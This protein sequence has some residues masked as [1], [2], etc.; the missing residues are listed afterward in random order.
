MSLT[1]P[2][3]GL[4]L[5]VAAAVPLA[6]Q[7]PEYGRFWLG[8]DIGAGQGAVRCAS[9]NPEYR[10]GLAGHV[11]FGGMATRRLHYG[12]E[13]SAWIRRRDGADVRIWML[14]ADLRYHLPI[15]PALSLRTGFGYLAFLSST[16]GPDGL[17]AEFTSE[18][19]A[20]VAGAAYTIPLT[21]GVSL[22]PFVAYSRQLEGA[23][24]LEQIRVDDRANVNLFQIGLGLTW[25]QSARD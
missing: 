6:A 3:A 15:L 24:R 8:V 5:L 4:T 12:T 13:L 2:V 25:S 10:P 18:G 1:M 7:T 17:R 19:W 23:L 22:D 16:E 11:R 21:P 20:V 9:C 14:S